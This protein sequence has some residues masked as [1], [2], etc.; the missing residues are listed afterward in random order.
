MGFETTARPT[1]TVDDFRAKLAEQGVPREHVAFRCAMCGCVQSMTSLIR[2][3]VKSIE[4][5]EKFIGF[6]CVGRLTGAGTPNEANRG[7]GCNWTLGGLFQAH[8]LEV[9]T[10]DGKHH[11]HFVP[12]TPEEA[13]RLMAE[14]GAAPVATDGEPQT[15]EG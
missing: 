5:A 15:E 7:K 13:Q 10:P 4:E 3:G 12:A 8:D 2:A 11:P 6:S 9:V 14:H 1:M